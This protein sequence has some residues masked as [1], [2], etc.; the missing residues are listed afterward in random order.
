MS[1]V[2]LYQQATSS[3]PFSTIFSLHL[4]FAVLFFPFAYEVAYTPR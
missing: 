4:L 1:V 2:C 3:I